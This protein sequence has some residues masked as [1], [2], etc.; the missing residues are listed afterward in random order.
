MANW[1]SKVKNTLSRDIFDWKGERVDEALKAFKPIGEPTYKQ[2]VAQAGEGW[3]TL[4][5]IPGFGNVGL[6]SFNTFY[7]NHINRVFENEVQ[8]ILEYRQMA[9]M[10]EISD[11]IEDATNESIQ[12]DETGKF[13]H[14]TLNDELENNE[15]I[16]RNLKKE[17]SDLFYEKMDTSTLLWNM[18]RTY[19]VDGRVYY[20]R[21]ID[22]N[23]K[24]KGIINMKILPSES[25][26][27]VYDPFTG[28]VIAYYQYL[29]PRTKRPTNI[30]EALKD[31]N[32]VV[33]YPDQIGFINYGVFG[34]TRHEILG[35]L[36]KSR[37]PYNQLKLL[38]TSVIIYRIVRAPERL[39]FRIDTGNMPRDKALKYVEKIK[40]RMTKKQT[41]NPATGA[42]SQEPEVLSILENY[43]LPQCLRTTTSTINLL[44][45]RTITLSQLIDEHNDGKKHE[46]YSIEQDTGKIIRGEVEWAGIT[47]KDAELVRVYLDNDEFIDCTPD[48]K[49]VMRDGSEKEAQHLQEN[50]SLMP[51]YLREK[52]L[53][54][55]QN[56][57]NQLLDL[58]DN[59]W[60]FVHRHMG[61]MQKKGNAIHHND[62]DRY[63]N[64][65]DNLF[66]MPI[67]EHI[68][69]HCDSN[70]ERNSHIPLLKGLNKP[71]N[72]AKQKLAAKKAMNKR[73]ED[74]RERKKMG[75]HFKKC[76]QD[77]TIREK[78]LEVVSRPKTN[79][80]KK[81]LSI[82]IKKKYEDPLYC[83]KHAKASKDR[84]NDIPGFREMMS[85]KQSVIIDDKCVT[86]LTSGMI[87]SDYPSMPKL[88]SFMSSYSNFMEHWRKLNAD[89]KGVK[90]DS[91]GKQSFYKILEH[92]GYN[93]YTS[94]KKYATV[95]HKVSRVK[96]LQDRDDTG[97][98]TIKDPG[99]NHNFALAAGVF[100][101]NSADGRGSQIESVGG[102]SAGF[103]ELDD[104]YYFS[105]KMYRAL[106]YPL[107]RVSAGQEKREADIMFG[108][109]QTGEIT[110]DEVKW[111]RFLEAQQKRF[112]KD[113]DSLFLKHL[114]LRGLTKQYGLNR[115]SFRTRMNP[116]SSYR[117]QMDQN[118]METRFNNYQTMADRGEFSTYYLM[119][120]YLRWSEEEIQENLDGKKKDIELGLKPADEGF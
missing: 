71:K 115:W 112:C 32:I 80:W 34:R 76:W 118:F 7:N 107:S 20:E 37:I 102:Q 94:F 66:S 93:D 75:Q 47:R 83:K 8:R 48:H 108:G 42:L 3:E 111:S 68:K 1:L 96:V 86:Y 12:E 26:D 119:K 99:N 92:A 87:R 49:F 38:E 59:K 19:L 40:N 74:P 105:R 54:P 27:F 90:K 44:D 23:K 39:V 55:N 79:E 28:K 29:R 117:E 88:I 16:A 30:E 60:K 72:R 22:Q 15:N 106:K 82:S 110:R 69:L 36:E 24:T 77:P 81:N 101:K 62:F 85:K 10:A 25:M 41:Y 51:L 5:E 113:M 63:N 67:K 78:L 65:Y 2:T 4:T 14:L 6:S 17:F 61:P 31:P 50:E 109:S 21:I 52:K 95:N 13:L 89:I 120:K 35:F 100:V 97:C 104:I 56:E 84:W 64:M 43:Y 70:K 11:V 46:V 73:F 98:L 9:E 91:L 116:P 57:Y 45:G 114:E 58:K 18:F 33:F 103:T 53:G